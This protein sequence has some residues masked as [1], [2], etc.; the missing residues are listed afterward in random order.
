MVA[1]ILQRKAVGRTTTKSGTK[2]EVVEKK[3][4]VKAFYRT[5][6]YFDFTNQLVEIVGSALPTEIKFSKK[7]K[8]ARVDWR[9]GELENKIKEIKNSSLSQPEKEDL[10]ER[11]QNWINNFDKL[12]KKI[13]EEK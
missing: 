9:K 7:E 6:Q 3:P 1:K 10:I 8:L 2:K 5:K 12:F 4:E 11:F 13:K